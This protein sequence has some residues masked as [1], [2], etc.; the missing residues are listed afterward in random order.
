MRR[1]ANKEATRSRDVEDGH[2]RPGLRL[3]VESDQPAVRLQVGAQVGEM[4]VTI[5]GE[6]HV[7][8]RFEHARL[9]PAEVIRED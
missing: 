1:A 3:A 8:K 6:Q 4:Q 9:V 7:A 2:V 5:G